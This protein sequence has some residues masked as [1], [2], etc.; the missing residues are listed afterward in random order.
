MV[1]LP[2]HGTARQ[3]RAGDSFL[4]LWDECFLTLRRYA[5]RSKPDFF[6]WRHICFVKRRH[7]DWSTD[8]LNEDFHSSGTLKKVFL[9][10]E[11]NPNK[12]IC[13]LSW[14]LMCSKLD[15]TS[16]ERG[17]ILIPGV[18]SVCVF[19][20]ECGCQNYYF[21]KQVQLYRHLCRKQAPFNTHFQLESFK[22]YWL[23]H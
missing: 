4:G 2:S 22:C 9:W 11:E 7:C 17:E 5:P 3:W 16:F 6:F 1:H 21:T 15:N 8:F 14:S 12:N 20:Q 10:I 13:L 18:Y 23:T 19:L